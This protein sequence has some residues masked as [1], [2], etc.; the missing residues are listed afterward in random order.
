MMESDIRKALE[1]LECASQ[2]ATH[3]KLAVER[4]WVRGWDACL[5]YVTETLGDALSQPPQAAQPVALVWSAESRPNETCS[6]NHCTAETPFGRFLITW[7]G[8]KDH[9][10]PVVDETPWG[11]YFGSFGDVAAAKLACEQEFA[12]RIAA[13]A[14]A[15]QPTSQAETVAL[16]VTSAESAMQQQINDLLLE[17]SITDGYRRASRAALQSMISS[18]TQLVDGETVVG[19]QIKTGML[20]KLVAM[21]QGGDDPVFFP[22]NLPS[23][24][25][26]QAEPAASRCRKCGAEMAPGQAMGQTVGCSDEGT[27]SPAGPGKLIPCMKCSACGWSVTQ[28]NP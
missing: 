20:H 15:A 5:D 19:Y 21:N 2:Y 25:A 27:M 1:A 24:P 7:K 17:R 28:E 13:S 22:T 14:Q 8:W 9:D 4:G 3:N 18:A 11:G 16:Q 10:F 26:P 6:Y 12:R 23:Q